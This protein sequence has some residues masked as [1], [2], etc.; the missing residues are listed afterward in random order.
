MMDF[1]DE[2]DENATRDNDETSSEK[3]DSKAE[4]DSGD[5]IPRVFSLRNIHQRPQQREYTSS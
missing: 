4:S 3:S 1:D 2:C 5:E